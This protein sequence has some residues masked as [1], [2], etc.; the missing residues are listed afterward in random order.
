MCTQCLASSEPH[1]PGV[2]ATALSGCT[3]AGCFSSWQDVQQACKH[4][5][6]PEQMTAERSGAAIALE[7]QSP[8]SACAVP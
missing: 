8:D 3:Q 2:H 1:V 6:H 4:E 5:L 7:V